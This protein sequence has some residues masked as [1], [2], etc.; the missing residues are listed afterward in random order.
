MVFERFVTLIW[1]SKKL[2]Q[3]DFQKICDMNL[4][5]ISLV[6][7]KIIQVVEKLIDVGSIEYG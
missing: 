1:S 4:V 2:Y 3:F 5:L 6:R 7:D